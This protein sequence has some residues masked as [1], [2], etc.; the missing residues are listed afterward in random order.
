MKK[1]K[2]ITSIIK[3]AANNEILMETGIHALIPTTTF[4]D[5]DY[6]LSGITMVGCF[7]VGF[8]LLGFAL[9]NYLK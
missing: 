3:E 8:T 6:L 5:D 7:S 2:K 9:A 4:R 1:S